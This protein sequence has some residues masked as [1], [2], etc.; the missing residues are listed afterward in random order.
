[1]CGAG[2]GGRGPGFFGFWGIAAIFLG[3][4]LVP[5][6]IFGGSAWASHRRDL[7]RRDFGRWLDGHGCQQQ[8]LGQVS[9]RLSCSRSEKSDFLRVGYVVMVTGASNKKNIKNNDN[10]MMVM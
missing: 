9:C 7:E 2:S 3:F 10:N 8:R 5:S 4:F 6:L 1:M